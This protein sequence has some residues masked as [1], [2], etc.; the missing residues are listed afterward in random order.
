MRHLFRRDQQHPEEQR[1]DSW[2]IRASGST[3]DGI[4]G[5]VSGYSSTFWAVDSYFTA[6]H[7]DAFTRTL[8]ER[9]DRIPVLYG[10]DS[11][12][13]IGVPDVQRIDEKGLYIE[14]EV[15]DDGGESSQLMRRLKAGARY[16]FSFGFRLLNARPATEDDPLDFSQFPNIS[17]AEVMVYTEVKLYEHSI[18][19]FPANE[20]ATIESV[21]RAATADALRDVL[22]A[23]ERGTLS[24]SERA[25]VAQIVAALPEQPDASRAPL[26]VAGARRAD[27]DV[28]LAK[29]RTFDI[30]GGSL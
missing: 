10:H 19:S 17:R 16:G 25:I 8:A 11:E 12:R 15:F 13:N 30:L 1:R 24:D 29:L 5:V 27:L 6:M 9:E 28:A 4:A 3:R 23:A 14:V 7:P 22:T 18:V 21:R 26:P 20:E 2:E